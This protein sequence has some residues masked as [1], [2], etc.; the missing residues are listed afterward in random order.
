M[1][2]I[3]TTTGAGDEVHARAERCAAAHSCSYRE[4]VIATLAADKQLA[5]AYAQ[6]AVRVTAMATKPAEKRSQP[7]VPVAAGE[8]REI[9]EWLLRALRD[10]MEGALPG[11]LGSLALEAAGFKR[12]G[13][14]IE[15]AARRAM[16]GNPHLVTM[17]KLLLGDVR[18][19]APE[20]KPVPADKAAAAGLAQGMPA[21][22]TVHSRAQ[23]LTEKTPSLTYKQAVHQVLNDDPALKINYARS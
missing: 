7:A 14:P 21:G 8:E 6:P 1:T 13:M 20:N 2:T 19:N 5:E 17:A 22:E 16:D 12:I 18:R 23:A 10:N 3:Q 9:R 4:G 15:E 11:A